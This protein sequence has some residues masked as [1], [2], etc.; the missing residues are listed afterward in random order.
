MFIL[1]IWTLRIERR[2]SDYCDEEKESFKKKEVKELKA[3]YK[4]YNIQ[5]NSVNI[6]SFGTIALSICFLFIVISFKFGT[7]PLIFIIYLSIFVLP[8]IIFLI[9][10]RIHFSFKRKPFKKEENNI[11]NC[12]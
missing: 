5:T 12:E 4:I 9:V 7:I 8:V 11:K 1:T 3:E 2:S 6:I 10:I